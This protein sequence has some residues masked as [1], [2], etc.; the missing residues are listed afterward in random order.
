MTII[1]VGGSTIIT[2][3]YGDAA[4]KEIETRE[5]DRQL[6]EAE[7]AYAHG[8]LR[9][10][11]DAIA[12]LYKHRPGCAWPKWVQDGSA[13]ALKE[14]AYPATRPSRT[15]TK[16][17]HAR[18]ETKRRSDAIDL[19][20]ATHIDALMLHGTSS[21]AAYQAASD[22][23]G[24]DPAGSKKVMETT[25]KRFHQRVKSDPQR[26]YPALSWRTWTLF[27]TFMAVDQGAIVL[28][29]RELDRARAHARR[30]LFGSSEKKEI[31]TPTL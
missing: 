9:G 16:G 10:L 29:E 4:L 24:G 18:E 13:T 21:N 19:I 25:Y 14:V 27:N 31:N 26:Y 15:T 17:R 5:V 22:Q 11:A 1:K 3:G 23:L 28:T 7:S 12:L 2:A 8:Q 30:L 6:A 20:R